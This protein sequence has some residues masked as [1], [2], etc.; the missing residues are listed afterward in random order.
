M[1]MDFPNSP[2]VGQVFSS[3]SRQWVWTGTT[4]DSPAAG[5]PGIVSSTGG[6]FTGDI[7]APNYAGKGNAIITLVPALTFRQLLVF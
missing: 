7:T 6:T 3:G 4:W 5:T 2:V 1:A